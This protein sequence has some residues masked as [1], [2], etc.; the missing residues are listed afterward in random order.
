MWP[1]MMKLHMFVILLIADYQISLVHTVPLESSIPATGT[2]A[3]SALDFILLH[4]NDLHGRFD[5]TSI[6]RM[7]CKPEESRQN[8]CF[9]GFARHST[10]IKEHRDAYLRGNGLPVL[11]MNA[12]DTFTGT[13]WF[14]LFKDQIAAEMMNALKPDVG[15]CIFVSY[16][17]NTNQSLQRNRKYYLKLITIPE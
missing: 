15:V 14:F 12:G 2:S 6:V 5:E 1:S 4:N 13:T 9:G 7:D 16:S 17:I 11:Y 10:V 8:K 3:G